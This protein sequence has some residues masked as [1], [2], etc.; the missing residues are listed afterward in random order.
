[1]ANDKETR[2][3]NLRR[4]VLLVVLMIVTMALTTVAVYM[5]EWTW[6]TWL[7]LCAIDRIVAVNL[8]DKELE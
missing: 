4:S 8:D 5:E 2:R 1:M 7:G 6:A 3:P